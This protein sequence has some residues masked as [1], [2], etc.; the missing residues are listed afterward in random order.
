[1]LQLLQQLFV[2]F[3]INVGPWPDS[4]FSAGG[5]TERP[6]VPVCARLPSEAR[7][8]EPETQE[9]KWCDKAGAG[10]LALPG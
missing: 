9:P 10:S 4:F 6:D 8:V 7:A 5:G 3:H 2:K 1:M